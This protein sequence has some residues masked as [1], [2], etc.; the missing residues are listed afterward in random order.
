[1]VKF[2]YI[3][4]YAHVQLP[5]EQVIFHLHY[6]AEPNKINCFLCCIPCTFLFIYLLN[7]L[8]VVLSSI[9]RFKVS[10]TPL[11]PVN[12]QGLVMFR[13]VS[14]ETGPFW[15]KLSEVGQNINYLVLCNILFY[16]PLHAYFG[17]SYELIKQ[18]GG[19]Y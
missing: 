5:F 19:A 6:F 17:S 8:L 4:L 1:M 18:G 16:L 14:V 3:Q 9:A 12:F 2:E 10:A 11:K 7:I 13:S 15:P